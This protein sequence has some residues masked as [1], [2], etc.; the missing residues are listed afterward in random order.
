MSPYRYESYRDFIRDA[1]EQAKRDGS[2]LNYSRLAKT[3]GIQKSY[4]SQVLSGKCHLNADQVYRMAKSLNL[5]ADACEFLVL[6]LEQ[7]RTA[8]EERRQFL[9]ARRTELAKLKSAS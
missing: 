7:E 8:I 2:Q 6:L 3:M 9:N 1:V 4:L 5:P